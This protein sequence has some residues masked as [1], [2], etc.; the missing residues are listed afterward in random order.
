MSERAAFLDD[1]TEVYLNDIKPENAAPWEL[2]FKNSKGGPF[3]AETGRKH[4]L[5]SLARAGIEPCGRTPYSLRHTFDTE[6]LRKLDRDAVND[7]MGHTSYRPEYDHRDGIDILKKHHETR[8]I[9]N[10]SFG[11]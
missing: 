5:Y 4:F 7:L 8:K 3:R 2:I 10:A 6:M 11:K 9:V 1:I